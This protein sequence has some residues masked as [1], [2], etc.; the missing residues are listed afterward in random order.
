MLVFGSPLSSS[1]QVKTMRMHLFTLIQL[2][3][4]AVLWM[5]KM[6]PFSLA[7]PFALILT[8]PLRMLMTGRLFSVTEMKC[9]SASLYLLH[10]TRALCYLIC[11]FLCCNW[12]CLCFA[13]GRRWC[14][15]DVWGGTWEGCVR[16][17]PTAMNST[18]SLIFHSQTFKW[19]QFLNASNQVSF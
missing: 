17:V 6:S 14:Q 2:V 13:A 4:L 3:C 15:S 11:R 10:S 5:V 12:R 7:L 19:T 8:I 9:V 18:A 1:V 16:W